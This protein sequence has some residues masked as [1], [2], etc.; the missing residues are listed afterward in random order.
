[1]IRLYCRKAEGNDTLCGKCA[2]LL[3]Y[4]HLR[5]DKCRYGNGKSSCR[6]C[7]THCYK[8]EMRDRIRKVMRFSGP[9]MLLYHPVEAIRHMLMR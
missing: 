4:A 7:K 3:E 9:Q 2:E 6:N 1:M 5:L 8:P